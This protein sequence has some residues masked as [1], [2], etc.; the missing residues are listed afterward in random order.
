MKKPKQQILYIS[1]YS[2]L[3]KKFKCKP[4]I[5][6]KQ[7][8]CEL[9]KHFLVPKRCRDYAIKELIELNMINRL[10]KDKLEFKVNKSF[11]S[12]LSNFN[13]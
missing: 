2:L 7:L 5:T 6:N 4:F 1:I 3:K 8:N 11:E 13:I 9:G 12:E 10:D